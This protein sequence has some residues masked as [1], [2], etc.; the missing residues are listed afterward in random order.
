MLY[1]LYN[2][3]E[4][5]KELLRYYFIASAEVYIKSY[6][7]GLTEKLLDEYLYKNYNYHLRPLC[8]KI[9]KNI[10]IFY[11]S[12][13]EAVVTLSDNNLDSLSQLITFGNSEIKGSKILKDA[14]EIYNIR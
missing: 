2:K 6:K 3:E 7:F 1:T 9:L 14:V 4:F 12:F 13:S 5:P 11:S 10:N 8:L